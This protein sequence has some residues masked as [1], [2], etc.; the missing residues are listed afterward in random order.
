LTSHVSYKKNICVGEW[1]LYNSEI[2]SHDEWT[3]SH[4]CSY[5]ATFVWNLL[6]PQFA[7]LMAEIQT[8]SYLHSQI[9][10]LTG[11]EGNMIVYGTNEVGYYEGN[12]FYSL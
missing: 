12:T 11:Y 1:N 6:L 10:Q 7:F 8:P 5:F 3:M 2:L 9:V 4:N